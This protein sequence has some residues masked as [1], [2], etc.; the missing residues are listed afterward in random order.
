MHRAPHDVYRAAEKTRIH[1]RH[2]ADVMAHCTTAHK[3][4]RS[5]E[6]MRALVNQE[7]HTNKIRLAG[8]RDIVIRTMRI[9]LISPYSFNLKF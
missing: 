6:M 7:A 5:A 8:Y 1:Y 3:L 9:A 2:S 4:P